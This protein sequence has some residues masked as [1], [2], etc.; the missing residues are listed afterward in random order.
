[1]HQTHFVR[2]AQCARGRFKFQYR[3][4]PFGDKTILR[5]SHFHSE[6]FYAGKVTYLYWISTH[7]ASEAEMSF[8]GFHHSVKWSGHESIVYALQT[9]PCSTITLDAHSI[10]STRSCAKDIDQSFVIISWHKLG[11]PQSVGCSFKNIYVRCAFLVSSCT[12]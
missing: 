4:S 7:N 10:M 9:W 12:R 1:M 5:Q 6:I 8:M 11:T 3:K 2:G